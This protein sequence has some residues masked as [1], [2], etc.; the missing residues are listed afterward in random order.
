M[1]VA[2]AWRRLLFWSFG[3]DHTYVE[4]SAACHRL[5][6]LGKEAKIGFPPFIKDV[7][8]IYALMSRTSYGIL[9][10]RWSTLWGIKGWKKHTKT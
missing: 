6:T 5:C 8:C 1:C 4:H 3:A 9:C 2:L 7:C 10:S